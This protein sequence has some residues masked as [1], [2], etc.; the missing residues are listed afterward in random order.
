[1]SEDRRLAAILI[2]DNIG[3][4]SRKDE[5]NQKSLRVLENKCKPDQLL[6]DIYHRKMV[7]GNSKRVSTILNGTLDS[8]HYSQK[9]FTKTL[10]DHG[11][12]IDMGIN[13]RKVIFTS[14]NREDI[15]EKIELVPNGRN[16]FVKG[17]R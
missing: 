7:K 15:T 14:G 16:L 12:M 3:S 4:S 13:A 9:T 5:N 11:L 8:V 2:S 6:I 1:M 10:Y 17:M